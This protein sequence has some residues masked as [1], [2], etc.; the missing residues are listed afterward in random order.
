MNTFKFKKSLSSLVI[1]LPILLGI[2]E[3]GFFQVDCL[4]VRDSNGRR[5]FPAVQFGEQ[6]KE[7]VNGPEHLHTFSMA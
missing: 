2:I 1:Q 4:T 6:E 5:C 3:L 7:V